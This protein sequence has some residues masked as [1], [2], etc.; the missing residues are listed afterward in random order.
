MFPVKCKGPDI[1]NLKY[2]NSTSVPLSVSKRHYRDRSRAPTAFP[3]DI[4]Q[5]F[6]AQVSISSVQQN[7]LLCFRVC[8]FNVYKGSNTDTHCFKCKHLTSFQECR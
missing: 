6:D 7:M 8:V 4:S 1:R 3:I 5:C 2:K